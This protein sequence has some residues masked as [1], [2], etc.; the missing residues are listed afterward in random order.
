MHMNVTEFNDSMKDK[1][2]LTGTGWFQVKK[3][4]L[5]RLVLFAQGLL[6]KSKALDFLGPVALRIYL[7]PIF[8]MAGSNKIDF[9]TFLPYEST[10]Q[11]F[12]SLGIPFAGFNAFLAGWTEVLG[13]ILLA[14]GLATRWIS[15]PLIGTMVVAIV[16]VHWHNGW[17]AIAEGGGL[18]AT[19]RTIAAVERLARAKEILKTHGDYSWLTEYGSFAMLNNGIEFAATYLIMLLVLLFIGGGR[20]FSADYWIARKYMRT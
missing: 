13:A 14:L 9:S 5:V 11:W 19:D 20:Y 6:N 17:L 12:A 16:T 1:N 8:W 4:K 3:Q 10:V 2:V 7:V 18:F 15:I